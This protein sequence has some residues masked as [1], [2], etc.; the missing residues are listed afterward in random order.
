MSGLRK[1]VAAL[2]RHPAAAFAATR[3][4]TFA[5]A[6]AFQLVVVRALDVPEYATYAFAL[7]GMSLAQSVTSFGLT[8]VIARFFSPVGPHEEAFAAYL[9]IRILLVR[10]S[11]G[12]AA[13][14]GIVSLLMKLLGESSLISF[15]W[16][17]TLASVATAILYDL[18]SIAIAQHRQSISQKILIVEVFLRIIAIFALLSINS[19]SGLMAQDVL[20]V[21][22]VSNGATALVLALKLRP[23]AQHSNDNSWDAEHRELRAVALGGYAGTLAW[24][25]M[26]PST[27]RA[28]AALQLSASSFAGFAFV[29]S[30]AFSLQRY[31]PGFLVLPLIEARTIR[32]FR[33]HGAER[34]GHPLLAL[35]GKIDAMILGLGIVISAAVGRPI[36]TY[37]TGG[38]YSDAAFFVP[39]ILTILVCNTIYR[40]AEVSATACGRSNILVWS[41]PVGVIS[42]LTL[43]A[44]MPT[45]GRWALAAIPM[46]DAT[47]R[48]GLTKRLLSTAGAPRFLDLRAL[49]GIVTAVAFW[50]TASGAAAAY[51]VANLSSALPWLIAPIAAFGY[52]ITLGFLRPI[53]EPEWRILSSQFPSVR[54]SVTS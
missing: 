23:A 37:L 33:S 35:P 9:F 13:T 50:A 39:A 43:W 29:H 4:T 53:G 14:A 15:I 41:L 3:L 31:T 21:T 28:I 40:S 6:I 49:L 2:S 12:A 30:I 19:T 54:T 10:I 51:A 46:L 11:I 24:L 42:A 48:V 44:T 47:V 7:A 20:T 27:T 22:A 5:L 34:N 25:V 8:R 36:I 38:K 32:E 16:I 1:F 52:A 26:S 18:D 45:L 17:P